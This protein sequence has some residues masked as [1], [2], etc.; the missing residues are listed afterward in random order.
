MSVI[1]KMKLFKDILIGKEIYFP[2]QV[3]A[4][5]IWLGSTYGGFN[6]VPSNINSDSIV[7]SFGV[8][9]DVSFDE[10]VIKTFG[11]KVYAFDPTPK[12]KI[13]VESET[14][15]EKFIFLDIGIA[16]YDGIAKFYLPQDKDHVS[17]TTYNRWQYDESETKPIE[18]PVKR[19]KTIMQELDHEHIDLLKMDIESSEYEVIPDI[20]SSNLPITQILVEVHHRFEGMDIGKTREMIRCLN[21]AGYKIA[22][23]SDTR[24]EYTFIK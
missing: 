1:Q 3:K 15:S 23:L 7:Y 19:L 8:G 24:E 11:C 21:S 18:V 17:C 10:D 13:F 2:I 22:A 16:N 9:T 20:I 14:R 4:K 6:V 12:S 5:S